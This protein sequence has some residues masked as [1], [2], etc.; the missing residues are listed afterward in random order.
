MKNS[1]SSSL[2]ERFAFSDKTLLVA[3]VCFLALLASNFGSE[4]RVLLV[5]D[6]T[7]ADKPTVDNPERGWGQMLP[8]FFR[9]NVI[10]TN[11]ARNGRSTKSFINE[12]RWQAV[13]D[14]LKSGDFVFI[15]FGHNDEK[16]ADSTRYA[17]PWTAYKEN[18]MRFV[19]ETKQ[20][21]ATPVLLTPVQRRKFDSTG[22]LVDTHGEYP[23]V[24]REIAKEQNIQLFD[25]TKQT[26]DFLNRLGSEGSKKIFVQIDKHIFES[27]P[28]GRED[29]THFNEYGATEIARLV[30]EDIDRSTLP[31]KSFRR[32]FAVDSLVGINKIVALDYFYN[33]EW[34]LVGD[35]K[36][37]FHYVWED[38]AN[39]GF[40]QL[41]DVIDHLGAYT[42]RLISAPTKDQ[43][44][45]YSVYI[46]V[47]PDTPEETEHPNYTDDRAATAI[48]EWVDD[49]GVLVLMA[50][51]K[52]NSEFKHFNTLAGKF[53]IQFNEDSYHRVVGNNFDEGK[54][55]SLPSH[56]IFSG[57]R[58]IYM[59]EICSLT[60][61][62]PAT[63]ILTENGR[64]FAASA[65]YGKGLV[66]AVGD[67][68][69]YNE[70]IDNRK[71]PMDFENKKA[72]VALF[73]W[74]LEQAKP[75]M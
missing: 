1:G 60:L 49:G 14:Q 55:S 2:F 53:G 36:T 66:F 39:S 38:S 68:W 20:K 63:E 71:L 65:R 27:L 28:D 52:G 58:Q 22:K 32:P 51:D 17:A 9:D 43:L 47:D 23:E 40:S 64:V 3:A 46:I 12:G 31:L 7:M 41:G 72:A 61:Q 42:T 29:N 75:V 74:L 24:V 8:L 44:S 33:C 13:L 59:K 57:V 73:K 6:S 30:A 35:K 45:H 34:K 4:T 26:T 48:A 67:P 21:G 18:L 16:T 37:Q 5:G 15:Q 25:L 70:Y 62:Q 50:N 69:L 11:C 56:P 10:F 19:R 54:F